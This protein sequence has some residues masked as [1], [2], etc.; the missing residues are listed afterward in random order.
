MKTK[1]EFV[2]GEV[3][4]IE[5]SEE[6]AEV[7]KELDRKEYND[8]HRETRRHC[9]LSVQGDQGL[10][11]VDEELD[12]YVIVEKKENNIVLHKAMQSLT[13]KQRD[14]VSKVYFEGVPIGEYA[15][16]KGISQPVASKRLA[17]AIKNMKKF[18]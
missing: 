13:E 17:S 8:N 10:W 7:L 9:T 5:V 18:F 4:E 3:V 11:L 16:I 6:W 1:Y 15:E 14:I 2:N 12:P